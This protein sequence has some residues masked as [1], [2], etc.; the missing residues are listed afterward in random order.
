MLKKKTK[1]NELLLILLIFL[2]CLIKS[3]VKPLM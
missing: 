2:F 1:T 3:V